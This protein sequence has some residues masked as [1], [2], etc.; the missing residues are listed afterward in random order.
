MKVKITHPFGELRAGLVYD[1]PNE[2][3]REVI[4]KDFGFEFFGDDIEV[5][6]YADKHQVFVEVEDDK[7]KRKAKK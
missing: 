3:A 2:E 4:E 7:A 5:T 1:L 6:T